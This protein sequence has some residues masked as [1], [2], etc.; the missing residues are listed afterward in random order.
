MKQIFLFF[1]LLFTINLNAQILLNTNLGQIDTCNNVIIYDS[2]GQNSSYGM[3]ENYTVTFCP[4]TPNAR[5]QLEVL[6]WDINDQFD[7]M[8]LYDG[9]STSAPLLNCFAH[10]SVTSFTNPASVNNTSGCITITWTTNGSGTA[11]GWTIEASC[12]LPCQQITSVLTSATPAPVPLN[13]GYIDIC[14]NETVTF[15]GQGSYPENNL[16]YAQADSTSTFVWTI[17]GVQYSGQTVSHQF[18]NP[19]GY[20]VQLEITDAQG[21][22]NTTSLDQRVRVAPPPI[23]TGTTAN[24]NTICVGD[25]VILQGF[26]NQQ[27]ENFATGGFQVDTILLE[28]APQN[29]SLTQ[30]TTIII[31]GFLPG[32]T[33]NNVNELGSVCATLEHDRSDQIDIE[34]VCPSGQIMLLHQNALGT[35]NYGFLGPQTAGG[36]YLPPQAGY[37][38]CWT[39]TAVG[40]T[41]TD[42]IALPSVFIAPP[43]IYVPDQSFTNLLGCELNGIWT[44]NITD[45]LHQGDGYLYNWG[46]GFP[47]STYPSTES[48][49]PQ[50]ITRQWL[51]HSSII[52]NIGDSII[53][54]VPT[55]AG[56]VAYTFMTTN[57]YG[58]SYDTTITVNVTPLTDGVCRD[59]DSVFTIPHLQ[60]TTICM[61]GS[62]NIHASV[63]DKFPIRSFT[64]AASGQPILTGDTLHA[65]LSVTNTFPFPMTTNELESVCLDIDHDNPE[66][67]DIYLRAPTG[68]RIE[69]STDNGVGTP[70][71]YANTC[72]SPTATTNITTATPPYTGTYLPE[73]SFN[74][75]NIVNNI[76]PIGIWILEIREDGNFLS[77][78]VL[79]SWTLNFKNQHTLTYVW[80]PNTTGLSCTNC[81]NPTV[82]PTTT[83]NYIVAIQSSYGCIKRDTMTV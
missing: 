16:L 3:N 54:V 28:D 10:G 60:D 11:Q 7:L 19:G 40:N 2:G 70:N 31:D 47:A 24:Q 75:I 36:S 29:S 21:C 14:P 72:F 23:F 56:T 13:N 64:Y 69:L 50:T 32:Q 77:D 63:V 55:E 58:C 53:T 15:S 22:K 59:C 74:L 33:L 27:T 44:L 52:S 82:T 45:N 67:L 62:V 26:L 80:T 65:K 66:D 38:Y 20:K 46:I 18:P 8:C 41:I 17:G 48:F 68:L 6:L 49:V 30:T 4:T 9:N 12:Q 61:G 39:P 25:T 83:A 73:Q 51:P 1:I 79:K 35:G 76:N 78:G 5:I 43:G 81:P 42:T 57:D 34:L 37:T 71:A